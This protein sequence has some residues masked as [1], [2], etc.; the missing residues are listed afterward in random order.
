MKAF[1]IC[2]LL[3]FFSF[4]SQG[5]V[6]DSLNNTAPQENI[7]V[8]KEYDEDGQL[9]RYD[10]T[11]TYSYSTFDKAVNVDS[12]FQSFGAFQDFNFPFDDDFWPPRTQGLFPLPMDSLYHPFGALDSTFFKFPYMDRSWDDLN[13]I[14]Q[15]IDSLHRHYLDRL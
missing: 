14:M 15:R 6:I 10:S 3:C 11:Y 7:V 2:S 12:L 9:I 8:N 4:E 1:I 5:Q 13:A